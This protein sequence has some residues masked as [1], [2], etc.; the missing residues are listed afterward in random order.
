[1]SP[2]ESRIIQIDTP[3]ALDSLTAVLRGGGLAVF[4]TDTVYGLGG[5]ISSVAAL[6]RI[7]ALKGRPSGKPLP[8]LVAGLAAAERL[9]IFSRAARRA[10][11]EAWPGAVTLILPA[12]RELPAAICRDGRVAVR[13][14]GYPPLLG[15]LET[16]QEG[17]AG[18]SANLS[19]E[20]APASL[21][22]VPPELSDRVELV[23]DGGILPGRPSRIID[24]TGATPM[25]VRDSQAGGEK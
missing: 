7:L 11:L 22:E 23:L 20:P 10:A 17:I 16:L 13:V 1:M 15:V 6:D 4:P 25:V 5:R 19:G 14:P 21:A 18:T 8:V 24:F 2:A 12:R 9:A 3:G